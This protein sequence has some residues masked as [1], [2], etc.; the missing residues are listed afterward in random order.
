MDSTGW[1]FRM[2]PAKLN[3]S[4]AGHILKNHPVLKESW[5]KEWP[6]SAHIDSLNWDFSLNWYFFNMKFHFGLKILYLKSRLYV[7]SSFGKS[8]LYC[9]C[10]MARRKFCLLLF[11]CFLRIKKLSSISIKCEC[12]CLCIWSKMCVCIMRLKMMRMPISDVFFL[13]HSFGYK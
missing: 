3:I 8:R 9:T 10:F 1:Y 7:K 6:L 11:F 12:V 2:C 5:D 4:L 13:L